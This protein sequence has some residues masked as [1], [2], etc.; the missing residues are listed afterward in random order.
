MGTEAPIPRLAQLALFLPRGCRRCCRD[1]VVA[2]PALNGPLLCISIFQ[3]ALL[4]GALLWGLRTL[5]SSVLVLLVIEAGA[6]EVEITLVTAVDVRARWHMFVAHAAEQRPAR[7]VAAELM[8]AF[9]T[10]SVFDC[11]RDAERDH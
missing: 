8:L 7:R 1:G 3:K 4:P 10:L 5:D 2:A 9:F 11:G 6:A